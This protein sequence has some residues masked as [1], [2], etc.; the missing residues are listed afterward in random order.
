MLI[1]FYLHENIEIL[2]FE[3]EVVHC[4]IYDFPFSRLFG[5]YLKPKIS[6]FQFEVFI[7]IE[8]QPQRI[9]IDE[10]NNSTRSSNTIGISPNQICALASCVNSRIQLIKQLQSYSCIRR[11]LSTEN[12]WCLK[13]PFVAVRRY[14]CLCGT[15]RRSSFIRRCRSYLRARGGRAGGGSN[16]ISIPGNQLLAFARR[17]DG[18][19]E[20][21][22]E[23]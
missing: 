19:V 22:K 14:A 5:D 11:Q 2:V 6:E 9:S 18:G 17:V 15:R 23:R 10:L 12:I 7:N 20:S 8:H 21:I 3:D 4:H 16:T 13:L 1:V